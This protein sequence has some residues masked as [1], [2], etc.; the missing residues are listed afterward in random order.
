MLL[1]RWIA[2]L[3]L[4][5]CITLLHPT[6]TTPTPTPTP[7]PTASTTRT[8]TAT[9]SAGNH[10]LLLG[11]WVALNATRAVDGIHLLHRRLRTCRTHSHPHP[12][13]HLRSR[14]CTAVKPLLLRGSLHL[15]V[16]L[17]LPAHTH[18]ATHHRVVCRIT[19]NHLTSSA[20][21]PA[22]C[23]L[24]PTPTTSVCPT[25][26]AT[27]A[28]TVCT[29]TPLLLLRVT[30]AHSHRLHRLHLWH[31]LRLRH[32]DGRRRCLCK[33]LPG[34]LIWMRWYMLHVLCCTIAMETCGLTFGKLAERC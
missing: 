22:T 11:G 32:C 24:N 14:L 18:L 13:T 4:D 34:N 12:H 16:L 2:A 10:S 1:D 26:T 20:P 9:A 7:T 30:A 21:A 8:L 28:G 33:S 23:R 31:L 27:S 19:R 25:S 3:L 17:L 6:P 5:L 15:H 29:P